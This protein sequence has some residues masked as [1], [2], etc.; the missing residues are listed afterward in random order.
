M[1]KKKVDRITNYM[2]ILLIELQ[3][4]TESGIDSLED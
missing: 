3:T 4:R 2:L 1:S